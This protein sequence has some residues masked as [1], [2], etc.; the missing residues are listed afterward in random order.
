MQYDLKIYFQ[1]KDQQQNHL[2]RL[3]WWWNM[4]KPVN[5]FTKTT[6]FVNR[7]QEKK[8]EN[9]YNNDYHKYHHWQMQLHGH[10]FW[11][12]CVLRKHDRISI[13]S[14]HA[15]VIKFANMTDSLRR[16]MSVTFQKGI[17]AG[18]AK[19]NGE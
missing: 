19:N 6:Y 5:I 15:Y 16:G 11:P 2:L 1:L 10:D 13:V 12:V 9:R 8:G 18:I 17:T 3:K 7:Q 4:Y 14:E